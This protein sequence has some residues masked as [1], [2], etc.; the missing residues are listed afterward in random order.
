MGKIKNPDGIGKIGNIVCV[1]PTTQVHANDEFKSIKDL[2]KGQKILSHDGKYHQINNVYGRGTNEKIL[3]LKNKLG[4]NFVTFD[5]LILSTKIPK[6]H[7]FSFFKN[8]KRF[9]KNLGWNHAGELE[10]GDLV[11]YPILTELKDVEKMP[12]R[13]ERLKFD[14]KSKSIPKTIKID[15]KFL[16]LVGYYLAEGYVQMQASRVRI[17]FVFNSKEKK[18]LEDVSCLIKNIFHLETKINRQKK[19]AIEIYVNSVAVARLFEKLFGKGAE[20]KHIPHF[21][22][23]L[24]PEKQKSLILGMWRGDGYFNVKRK[25]PR[26]GYSTISYQL[27]QQLSTLL[28]RQGIIPSIYEEEEKLKDGVWHRKSWRIHVGERSSAEHLAAILGISYKNKKEIRVHSWI[29]NSYAFL[30]ITEI[31]TINHK[32]AVYNLEVEGSKSFTSNAFCLH[33]CGDVMW[34]YIKVGKSASGRNKG[35]EIIS[36]VKFETFGCTAAIATSSMITDLAKGKTLEEALNID[37]TRITESLG[38]LPPIKVHCSVLASDALV[39]AI[40]DYF[41]K[42]GRPIS[43]ELEDRH[44]HIQREKEIIEEKYKDWIGKQEEAV[45]ETTDN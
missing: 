43:K 17:G 9:T 30:P 8:K 20:N 38:G 2:K 16:R 34:L 14:Y 31:K 10:K 19:T 5:H 15:D 25:W 39:E 1:I 6:T 11:A 40:Y 41:S 13:F 23:L 45:G 7:H 35:K 18:Y 33:N 4:K 44:K 27:V 26:A 37:K 36:D 28:L 42:K 3:L 21:M 24:P 22:M 12:T 32:G 29:E